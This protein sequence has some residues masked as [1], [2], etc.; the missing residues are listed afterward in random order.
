MQPDR[1]IIQNHLITDTG[2]DFLHVLYCD[3]C[4]ANDLKSNVNSA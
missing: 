4:T 3:Y 2:A 1:G